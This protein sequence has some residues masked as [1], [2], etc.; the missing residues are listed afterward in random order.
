MTSYMT[1]QVFW[2]HISKNML[3]GEFIRVHF[4]FLNM[5]LII[6]EQLS[7]N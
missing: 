1:E 6:Q 7:K 5:L 4:I 2:N 3:T